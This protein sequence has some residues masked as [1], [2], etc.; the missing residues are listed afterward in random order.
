MPKVGQV[1]SFADGYGFVVSKDN[2]RPVASF[3][4]KTIDDANAAHRMM[5]DILATCQKV[6][7]YE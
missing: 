5:Q 3:T 2:D 1:Q 7:G 4:F 6:R